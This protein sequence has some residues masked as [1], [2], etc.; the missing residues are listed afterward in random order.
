M[1]SA[2]EVA[3][4]GRPNPEPNGSQSRYSVWTTYI[5]TQERSQ[6]R[7]RPEFLKCILYVC[8]TSGTGPGLNIYGAL[9]KLDLSGCVDKTRE[10]LER[11]LGWETAY[12][13]HVRF[14]YHSPVSL[15]MRYLHFDGHISTYNFKARQ[16]A[17]LRRYCFNILYPLPLL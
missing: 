14:W 12:Q 11:I 10:I 13:I 2:N 16:S 8:P 9:D 17:M 1:T 7:R 6:F 5:R 4:G 15:W 3:T